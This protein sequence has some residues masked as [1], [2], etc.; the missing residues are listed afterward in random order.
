MQPG[1]M[2]GL[3]FYLQTRGD[4]G[5]WETVISGEDQAELHRTKDRWERILELYKPL[6]FRVV[7]D[8]DLAALPSH[9]REALWIIGLIVL[10]LFLGSLAFFGTL[11][12]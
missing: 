7:S 9:R 8:E 2:E 11:I 5:D 1:K 6:P 3:M 4:D 12:R 10:F